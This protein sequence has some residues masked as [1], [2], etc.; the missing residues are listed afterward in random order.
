MGH[1]SRRP[2]PPLC[3]LA[4]GQVRL[5]PVLRPHLPLLSR[6]QRVGKPHT[7]KSECHQPSPR[8]RLSP[9]AGL[10]A[11]IGARRARLLGVATAGREWQRARAKGSCI[12]HLQKGAVRARGLTG[13]RAGRAWG[14][15]SREG[16]ASPRPKRPAANR[17]LAVEKAA[18]G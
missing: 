16:N 18:R 15:G 2:A 6:G 8:A 10:M 9:V 17:L 5:L 11:P 3:Q 14:R 1:W 4:K 12:R 13:R 7:R